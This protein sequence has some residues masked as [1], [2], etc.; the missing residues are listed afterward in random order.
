MFRS[1]KIMPINPVACMRATILSGCLTIALATA[2]FPVRG[3]AVAWF[4]RLGQ[5]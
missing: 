1:L 3:L 4:R 5:E 2:M